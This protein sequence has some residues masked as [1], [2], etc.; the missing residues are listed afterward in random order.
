MTIDF[1]LQIMCPEARIALAYVRLSTIHGLTL[2]P[3]KEIA[4]KDGFK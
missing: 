3:G 1:F 2:M 4:E